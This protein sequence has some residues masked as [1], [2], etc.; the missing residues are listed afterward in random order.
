MK[1]PTNDVRRLVRS[2]PSLKK[3]NVPMSSESLAL[4]KDLEKLEN[5]TIHKIL[6]G[7][8]HLFKE[9]MTTFG[10]RLKSLRIDEYAANCLGI[11]DIAVLCPN[12]ESF[13]SVDE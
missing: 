3:L 10:D 4:L 2:L 1:L 7:E 6:R 13:W 8:A 5:L 12:P 11:L 9:S